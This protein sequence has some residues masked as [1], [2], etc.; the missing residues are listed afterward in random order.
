[1]RGS[2]KVL[3]LPH[4]CFLLIGRKTWPLH[5]S[6][7]DIC[8]WILYFHDPIVRGYCQSL[9]RV[10]LMTKTIENK[11]AALI[12]QLVLRIEMFICPVL[13]H[14]AARRSLACSTVSPSR[15]KNV[16]TNLSVILLNPSTTP[17]SIVLYPVT[18]PFAHFVSSH[19]S[20]SLSRRI[21]GAAFSRSFAS[22]F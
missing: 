18:T 22:T 8:R 14:F 6:R 13:V 5:E 9:V 17:F 12:A 21:S 7:S 1:M 3:Q 16:P 4:Q 11:Q 19:Y 2:G 15:V 20:F 10:S